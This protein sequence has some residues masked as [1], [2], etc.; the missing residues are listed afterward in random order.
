MIGAGLHAAIVLGLLRRGRRATAIAWAVGVGGVYPLVN[1]TRQLLEHRDD[2][3]R[4]G[5]ESDDAERAL[6]RMFTKGPLSFILGGAGFNRH[7][8]HHWDASISYTRFR[9]LERG[10]QST[11]AGPIMSARD[12]SY[13]AM[14]R[15]MWR[16]GRRR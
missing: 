3:D 13:S 12:G 5:G 10:L 16:A 6:T 2:S 11:S 14:F 7:L 15:R 4:S 9:E 1:S 8:L